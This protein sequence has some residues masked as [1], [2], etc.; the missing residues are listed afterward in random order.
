[1]HIRGSP[2]GGQAGGFRRI[3]FEWKGNLEICTAGPI[4]FHRIFKRC[5]EG[6]PCDVLAMGEPYLSPPEDVGASAGR[7]GP[8]ETET[9]ALLLRI[10]KLSVAGEE[11]NLLVAVDELLSQYPRPRDSV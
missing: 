3:N 4:R 5:R 10:G 2:L 9:G 1:M 11:R 6:T 8:Q 7:R